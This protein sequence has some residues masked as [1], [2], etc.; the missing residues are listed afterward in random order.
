MALRFIPK[1]K[2][3]QEKADH[4]LRVGEMVGNNITAEQI[5]GRRM[6]AVLNFC[7]AMIMPL[8]P[9]VVRDHAALLCSNS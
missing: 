2:N 9:V 5:N 3:T 8:Y 1:Q 6:P 7:A 4:P